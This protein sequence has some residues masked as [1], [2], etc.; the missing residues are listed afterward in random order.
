[1]EAK[2]VAT[3]LEEP[4]VRASSRLS[5]DTRRLTRLTTSMERDTN[6]WPKGDTFLVAD[7]LEFVTT[8]LE[9]AD[10]VKHYRVTRPLHHITNTCSNRHFNRELD[11]KVRAVRGQHPRRDRSEAEDSSAVR[12]VRRVTVP[13]L[14]ELVDPARGNSVAL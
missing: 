14:K 3:D 1:M 4:G 10:R 11:P 12:R 8:S 2:R 13:P 7:R 6:N 5:D 9:D